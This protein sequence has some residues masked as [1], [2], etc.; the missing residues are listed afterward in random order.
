MPGAYY[1]AGVVDE[2]EYPEPRRSSKIQFPIRPGTS[3]LLDM[4]VTCQPLPLRA[5]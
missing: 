3:G 4:P 2:P 5:V 1:Q